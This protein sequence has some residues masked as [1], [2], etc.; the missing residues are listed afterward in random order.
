MGQGALRN[1]LLMG[2]YSLEN[3]IH[4][5]GRRA[6]RYPRIVGLLLTTVRNVTGGMIMLSEK[7][8]QV[9]YLYR[10]I[11]TGEYYTILHLA[12]HS[13]TKEVMV[14]YQDVS[15]SGSVWVRPLDLFKKKFEWIKD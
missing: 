2:T 9:D 5:S 12:L 4:G 10:N 15:C 14:V 8:V 6:G 1:L 11:K 13:E 3:C 7:E